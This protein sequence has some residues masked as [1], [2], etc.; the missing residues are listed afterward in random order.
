M[1]A[2]YKGMKGMKWKN[3]DYVPDPEAFFQNIPR[4]TTTWNIQHPEAASASFAYSTSKDDAASAPSSSSS[5]ERKVDAALTKRGSSESRQV[6]MFLTLMEVPYITDRSVIPQREIQLR[7]VSDPFVDPTKEKKKSSIKTMEIRH[8]NPVLPLTKELLFVE[9]QE[10]VGMYSC[11]IDYIN[12]LLSEPNL[13]EDERSESFTHFKKKRK[14][15][16]K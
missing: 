6:D 8:T 3:G 7:T 1:T 2:Y 15:K 11:P 4:T 9:R 14:K 13:R 10:G 16:K 5:K 12:Y